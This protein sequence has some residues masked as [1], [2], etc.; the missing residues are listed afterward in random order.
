MKNLPIP[1]LYPMA[2]LGLVIGGFIGHFLLF[3]V[4]AFFVAG[5]LIVLACGILEL[6]DRWTPRVRKAPAHAWHTRRAQSCGFGV[7]NRETEAHRG[8]E[9][10]LPP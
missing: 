3:A 6:R 2:V 4:I 10:V 1:G 5:G 7:A 9:P 8:F